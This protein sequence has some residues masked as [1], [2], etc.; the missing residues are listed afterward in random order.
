LRSSPDAQ[1]E[2]HEVA[3]EISAALEKVFPVS[4]KTLVTPSS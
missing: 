2:I 4:W 3:D 1:W